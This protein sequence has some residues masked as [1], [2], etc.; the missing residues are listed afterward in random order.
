MVKFTTLDVSEA[1]VT[2]A[3]HFTVSVGG[4]NKIVTVASYVRI[5]IMM[6]LSKDI[7]N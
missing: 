7:L 2:E 6:E 3:T 5:P 1:N 4:I